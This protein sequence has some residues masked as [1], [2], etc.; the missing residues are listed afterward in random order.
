M[1]RL[2]LSGSKGFPR[3]AAPDADIDDFIVD[4]YTEALLTVRRAG[5]LTGDAARVLAQGVAATRV[6]RATGRAVTPEM[7]ARLTRSW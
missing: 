1:A 4:A 3:K 7:V 5:A 6:S 2:T